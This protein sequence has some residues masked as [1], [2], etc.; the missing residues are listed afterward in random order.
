MS[1]PTDTA[2]IAQY[3]GEESLTDRIRDH[4][5]GYLFIAPTFV[6]FALLFYFPILRGVWLTFTN[7]SIDGSNAFIGLDNYFWLVSNDL[8]VYSLAG[9][10]CSRSARSRCSCSSASSR[11]SC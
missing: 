2:K 11:R 6:M 10:S 5:I 3:V 4:W 8:F 7:F 9:R 1:Q